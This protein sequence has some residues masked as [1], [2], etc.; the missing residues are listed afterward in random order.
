MDALGADAAVELDDGFGHGLPHIGVK[1]LDIPDF[2]YHVRR[3]RVATV[4]CRDSGNVSG[5]G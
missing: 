3:I 1:S 4:S 5:E 2:V